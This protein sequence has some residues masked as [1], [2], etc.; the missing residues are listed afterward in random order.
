MG[1]RNV[2]SFFFFIL[3]LLLCAGLSMGENPLVQSNTREVQKDIITPLTTVPMINPLNP[4]NS[5][6]TPTAPTITNPVTSPNVASPVSSSGGGSWCVAIQSA[7]QSALQTAIDYACGFGGA[8]CSAIQQGGSCYNPNTPR[9]HAS[10]AFNSYYQKNPVPNSC[11][12]GG[13][14]IITNVDP[15]SGGCQYS[16][17]STSSSVL[18]T[19]NPVG[20]TVYGSR[21][22]G[23]SNSAS[24][25]SRSLP[26]YLISSCLV[27]SYYSASF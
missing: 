12:F 13:T 15:S 7:S 24:S 14:A 26:L 11:N 6:T 10:Y 9:D 17:T 27:M 4:S 20:A 2:E 5:I 23:S 21:P 25:V 3:G 19:T 8:D 22:S 18:N 16:S 1:R